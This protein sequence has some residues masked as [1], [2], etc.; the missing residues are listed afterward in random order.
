MSRYI[1]SPLSIIDENLARAH[2][3]SLTD[4]HCQLSQIFAD[5]LAIPEN[6]SSVP[7]LCPNYLQGAGSTGLTPGSLV[8]FRGMVQDTSFGQEVFISHYNTGQ[9]VCFNAYRDYNQQESSTDS[10]DFSISYETQRSAMED[11][12]LWYATSAPG[13]SSWAKSAMEVDSFDNSSYVQFQNSKYPNSG[14]PHIGVILKMY[15]INPNNLPANVTELID[16]VGVLGDNSETD[17]SKDLIIHVLS[18]RK[19]TDLGLGLSHPWTSSD[20]PLSRDL[21][22]IRTHLLACISQALGGDEVAGEYILLHLLGRNATPLREENPVMRFSVLNLILPEN[23]E[24]A[25]LKA[26]LDNLL[27]IIEVY[28]LSVSGLNQ[29]QVLPHFEEEVGGLLAGRLQLPP[30]TYLVIDELQMDEGQLTERGVKNLQYIAELATTSRLQYLYPYFQTS[31][32]APMS[33]LIL[34]SRAKA[35]VPA[36]VRVT[37]APGEPSLPANLPWDAYRNYIQAVLRPR[38]YCIPED[39]ADKIQTG[40]VEGRQQSWSQAEK[41]A[42]PG[43][44][45]VPNFTHH[46]LERQ[47]LLARLLA[48]SLDPLA[49]DVQLTRS[50]WMHAQALHASTSSHLPR[51]QTGFSESGLANSLKNINIEPHP[52]R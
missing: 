10:S 49:S 30:S 45:L 13:I 25:P 40:F 36:Q 26:V 32:P 47:L 33:I 8:R 44:A 50:V 11:R 42:E 12:D 51:S 31:L 17:S 27:P 3:N 34:S 20:M 48:L 21:P 37:V 24:T 29:D 2:E 4:A 16:V 5:W 18:L 15:G 41:T 46:D 19:I 23:F 9:G 7:I 52:C 28:R 43:Q 22:D 35:L 1:S 39:I 6:L 38:S 14:Q